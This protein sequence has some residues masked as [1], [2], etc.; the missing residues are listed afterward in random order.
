MN[1]L[2]RTW[3][4]G[5]RPIG[6]PGWPELALKVASTYNIDTR[7]AKRPSQ[8]FGIWLPGPIACTKIGKI[9]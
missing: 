2:N 3:A 4:A 1:L 7:S 6:A 5:A 9:L 8:S